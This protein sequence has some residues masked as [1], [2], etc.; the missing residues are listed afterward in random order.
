MTIEEIL[1]HENPEEMVREAA[2]IVYMWAKSDAAAHIPPEVSL[3]I[4]LVIGRL[5][6]LERDKNG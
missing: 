4:G 6:K 1:K 2:N 5:S 3:S